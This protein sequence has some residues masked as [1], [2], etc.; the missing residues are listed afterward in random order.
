MIISPEGMA[1]PGARYY[2]SEIGR[3]LSV[4]PLAAARP[5]L[6]PY[7]YCQ[8]NP[9]GRIDPD[10]RIDKKALANATK[11]AFVSAIGMVGS[12][13]GMT[14]SAGATVKTAGL[15]SPFSIPAFLGSFAAFGVSTGLFS[16]SIINAV[17][18]IQTPNGMDAKTFSAIKQTVKG[19]GGGKTAEEVAKAIAD[20]YGLG[21]ISKFGISTLTDLATILAGVELSEDVIEILKSMAEKEKKENEKDK[22]KKYKEVEMSEDEELEVRRGNFNK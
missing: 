19:L 5:G 7:N 12:V 17:I 13:V 21:K 22:H 15:S 18:A 2:D 10:G 16:E 20:G 6:S 9:L 4:D 1:S 8:N 14:A 11:N 3:W